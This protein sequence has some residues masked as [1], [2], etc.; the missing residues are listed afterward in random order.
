M[1]PAVCT[2]GS[3]ASGNVMIPPEA[4]STDSRITVP[5]THNSPSP[6]TRGGA[7]ASVPWNRSPMVAVGSELA[8]NTS[9]SEFNCESPLVSST[10]PSAFA[11]CGQPRPGAPA[12]A[13]GQAVGAP[14]P[15]QTVTEKSR[16][17]TTML[18][19]AMPVPVATNNRE[20]SALNVMPPEIP[21]RQGSCRLV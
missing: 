8:V 3:P 21:R 17:R 9:V 10:E 7:K 6:K 20:P 5:L 12:T 14:V 4:V 18:W 2:G 11:E 13:H 1:R 19:A 16:L 15:S